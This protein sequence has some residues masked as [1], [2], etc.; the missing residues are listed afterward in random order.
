MVGSSYN[1]TMIEESQF[2]VFNLMYNAIF[3][4][5]CLLTASKDKTARI[6][7]VGCGDCM[8]IFQHNDYGN[9]HLIKPFLVLY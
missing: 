7:Q 6:W 1:L 3:W 8:Q 4:L 2:M 5:Q 9:T